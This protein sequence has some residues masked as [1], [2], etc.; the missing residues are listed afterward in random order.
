M[1]EDQCPVTTLQLSSAHSQ[2]LGGVCILV[3]VPGGGHRAH[4]SLKESLRDEPRFPTPCLSL[5]GQNPFLGHAAQQ[6][7]LCRQKCPTTM[8]ASLKDLSLCG[9]FNLN[10]LTL[11]LKCTSKGQQDGSVGK[12]AVAKPDNLRIISG[13]HT[14]EG[15]NWFSQAVL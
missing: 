10:K 15:R 12:D 2:W 9:Y 4:P 14:E 7:F 13:I 6:G 3:L 1:A 11:N 8:L 5:P